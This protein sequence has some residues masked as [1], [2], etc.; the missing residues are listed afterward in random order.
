MHT[1]IAELTD[2]AMSRSLTIGAAVREQEALDSGESQDALNSKMQE[3]LAGVRRNA[4]RPQP[5][6]Q[7]RPCRSQAVHPN[8]APTEWRW[9]SRVFWVSY[10]IRWP[11]W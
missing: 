1:S 11:D 9:L 7:P 4:V 5:W 6:R 10:A 3:R 8:S 2:A